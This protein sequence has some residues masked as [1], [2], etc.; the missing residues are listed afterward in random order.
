MTLLCT[1]AADMSCRSQSWA[2]TSMM[3]SSP[4]PPAMPA[5]TMR[6]PTIGKPWPPCLSLLCFVGELVMT[7]CSTQSHPV[8]HQSA[9]PPLLGFVD[10]HRGFHG[11]LCMKQMLQKVP[12]HV[13]QL[14]CLA[15]HGSLS[16]AVIMGRFVS[17]STSCIMVCCKAGFD[18]CRHAPASRLCRHGIVMVFPCLQV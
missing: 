8:S 18:Q 4:F 16:A 10:S 13:R 11:E 5:L 3:S 12:L 9:T 1:Y 17:H 7:P 15:V 2:A 14:S 6:R